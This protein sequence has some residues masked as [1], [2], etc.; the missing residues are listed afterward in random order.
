MKTFAIIFFFAFLSLALYAQETNDYNATVEMVYF[1]KYGSQTKETFSLKNN[2]P[3]DITSIKLRLFYYV[4]DNCID[5]SD[6]T[7]T[8]TIPAGLIKMFSKD[9]FDKDGMFVYENGNDY[10]KA[11]YTPFTVKYRVIFFTSA[12]NPSLVQPKKLIPESVSKNKVEYSHTPQTTNSDE[13]TKDEL[14]FNI[15]LSN[16]TTENIKALYKSLIDAGY[17][18]LPD[19]RTFY[20]AMGDKAKR[21]ELYNALKDDGYTDLPDFN[22]FDKAMTPDLSFTQ[23]TET[24]KKEKELIE[25]SESYVPNFYIAYTTNLSNLRKK[26]DSQSTKT[27]IVPKN[28]VICVDINS[29]KNGYYHT[30]YVD[31]DID[32]W[33][34]KNNVRLGKKIQETKGEIFQPVGKSLT[35]KP[36]IE[37]YN[38]SKYTMT[39]RIGHNSF[40]FTPRQKQTVELNPGAVSIIAS[41]P[42]VIPYIG[43]DTLKNNMEYWWE[44]FIKTVRR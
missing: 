29:L 1:E 6:V 44:F 5:T 17:S 37:I 16:S 24:K 10:K 38:N 4:K 33:I 42:G 39:L 31:K 25:N 35:Y 22:T 27:A 14:N 12:I 8:E 7:V 40:K 15:V 30:I 34:F 23:K 32:G 19:E 28:S 26:A 3:Y 36:S 2:A 11:N 13:D 21:E 41:A 18:D 43:E 9:S 20:N